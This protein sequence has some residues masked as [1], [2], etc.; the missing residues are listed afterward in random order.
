ML[1]DISIKI[2]ESNKC[3]GG[4]GE[5]KPYYI[6]GGSINWCSLCVK[7]REILKVLHKIQ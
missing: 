6:L 7:Q 3:W 4:F 1:P 5:K 2:F